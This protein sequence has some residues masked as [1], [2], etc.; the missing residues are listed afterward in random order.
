MVR[1]RDGMTIQE[2]YEPKSFGEEETFYRDTLDTIFIGDHV[3]ELNRNVI[4]RLA[5]EGFTQFRTVVVKVRFADFETHTRARTLPQPADSV[6]ALEREAWKLLLP[7]LDRR[8]NPIRK[9][10]RLIGVRI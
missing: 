8:E 9:P 7:F 2:S 1:V 4:R 5:A 3:K 10:I 6:T